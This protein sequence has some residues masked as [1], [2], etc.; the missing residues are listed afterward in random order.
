MIICKKTKQKNTL[1]L[2]QMSKYTQYFLP[3]FLKIEPEQREDEISEQERKLHLAR[4][5]CRYEKALNVCK[6][7]FM[8]NVLERAKS[9]VI[10][11]MERE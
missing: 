9:D 10:K 2:K 6:N 5:F 3:G 8:R 7:E 11:L 4:Q 1:L